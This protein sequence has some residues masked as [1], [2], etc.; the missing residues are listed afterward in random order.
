LS[1]FVAALSLARALSAAAFFA[2]S[3]SFASRISFKV[4]LGLFATA[5]AESGRRSG[6]IATNAIQRRDLTYAP[7]GIE[8]WTGAKDKTASLGMLELR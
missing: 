7:W 1:V 4:G 3:F 5:G 8:E 6:M 2:A